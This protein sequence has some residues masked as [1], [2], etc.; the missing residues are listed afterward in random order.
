MEK[1]KEIES[2][3]IKLASPENILSWSFGEV[4]KPETI[5]YRT[6]KPD[7]DGLFSER[8]FGPVKNYECYCGKLKGIKFKGLKCDRCG[9]EITTSNVRRERM[10]HISLAIPVAHIWFLRVV[11]S[12]ISLALDIPL[13]HL[14]KVIYYSAYIITKVNELEKRRVREKI[15]QEFKELIKNATD[16]KQKEKIK[17]IYERNINELEKIKVKNVLSDVEYYEYSKKFGAIFEVGIGSEPIKRF[18]EEIDL[19]KEKR[20][21]EE[22]LKTVRGP[23]KKKL[24]LRLKLFKN[25]IKNKARPEWMFL[26]VL[27]VIPPDLRPTIQLE[28]GTYATSDL[29]D[30]YRRV[31]NRNN[32]LKKLIE[33]KAP[34]I[35]LRN[36]KRMLQEAVDALL[37]N[38]IKKTQATKKTGGTR[39]PLKS[40]AESLKG[41]EGRFR[42]NLLG[43]RVDF[44]GR[45]VIVVGPE[46]KLYECGIPKTLALELFRP[47]VIRELLNQGIAQNISYANYL[48]ELQTDEVWSALEN[49]IKDKYVLLNRAPTLHRLGIQAFKPILVEGL[50]IRI[51]PFVCTAFNA[52]FDGD[53]MAVHLPLLDEAQIEARE[54]M[55]S[56]KNILKPGS[57]EPITV[58]TLDVVL[59]CYW[60][61]MLKP[62]SIGEGK[63]FYDENEALFYYEN[64]LIDLQAEILVKKIKN[65]KNIKTTVGRIIFNSILPE[66]FPFIN[67]QLNKKALIELIDKVYHSYDNE[68]VVNFLDNL[69]S[70]GFKYAEKSGLS[71]SI[72]DF[73]SFPEEKINFYNE[74]LPEVEN[75][76]KGFE[77]GLISEE[78]RKLLKIEVFSKF[79]KKVNDFYKEK[80]KNVLVNVPRIMIDSGSKGNWDQLTQMAS[81]KGLVSNPKGEVIEL[82]IISNYKEGLD[83]IEY[84]ISAHGARKGTVDTALKTAKA[85]YLTRRMVD[86]AQD[87]IIREFDCK[88][89]KGWEILR[90]DA[91]KVNEPFWYKIYSRFSLEKIVDKNGNVIVDVGD[92]IDKEKAKLIDELGIQ[93]IR[94]R[95]PLSCKSIYGVCVKCYGLD[96]AYDKVIKIGEACGIIAAQ[97]IGEPGTQLTMRTFHVGGIASAADITQGI[98]RV[99]ELLEARTP[100]NEAVISPVSGKIEEI[101]KDSKYYKI[102]ILTNSNKKVTLNVPLI[103]ELNVKANDII[104]KGDIISSGNLDP[105]KLFKLKGKEVTIRYLMNEVKKIYNFQG[106][107]IH[108]KHF[109]I[110]I[111]QMFSRVKIKDPGDSNFVQ[112]EIVEKSVVIE[113]NRELKK[114]GLKTIKA[115]EI[116]LGITRAALSAYSF[117]SAASFQETSR[118]LVKAA[119][120]GRVDKL[121][122][123]KENVI[124]GKRIPVGTGVRGLVF[125]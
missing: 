2:L 72:S 41:K 51:P 55:L 6:Q 88:D 58:P 89:T 21:I 54:I 77:S 49:V 98:P 50:A 71:L 80:V 45:S 109:E 44:S 84:F 95:S 24:L 36:E 12:R 32:R 38:T 23:E 13:Q 112:N 86:V 8:I 34:E 17:E 106:V 118:V 15:D 78:E 100:K 46:L 74:I 57:G 67:K 68:I 9:V 48:I 31:I 3:T 113:Q 103:L 69:K 101:R 64:G 104:N 75:I 85:G 114:A 40:L 62:G 14:E 99:E 111:R 79:V 92:V 63:I 26:T 37:D 33:L 4:T 91:E 56:S 7:K 42:K 96:L 28:T 27:P 10:G 94:V 39:R 70:L 82:P 122:G 65:E 117:L 53:Q 102:V 93:K 47:F 11:P 16:E 20:E 121:R 30:L 22:K 119:I 76:E 115:K 90:D 59:G 73:L 19:E 18:L 87:V 43:K 107:T 108:D 120:E 125:D 60:L 97:S 25:F 123:I 29:N 81:L 83:S 110:I 5:N 105:K 1:I 124:L 116:I 35:I 52:D 66:S 61:T